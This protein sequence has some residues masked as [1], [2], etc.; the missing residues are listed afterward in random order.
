MLDAHC[1]Q[2][3]RVQNLALTMLIEIIHDNAFGAFDLGGH[4]RN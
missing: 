4:P 1:E 2:S 3:I